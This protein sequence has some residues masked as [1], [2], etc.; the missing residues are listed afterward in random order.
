MHS[1][2][3]FVATWVDLEGTMLSETSHTGKTDF[4]YKCNLEKAK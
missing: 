3:P 2:L 4:T 1:I